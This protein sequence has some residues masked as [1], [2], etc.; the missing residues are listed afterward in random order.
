[1]LSPRGSWHPL[2]AEIDTHNFFGSFGVAVALTLELT[3]DNLLVVLLW[4]TAVSRLILLR[5]LTLM[6]AFIVSRHGFF[7]FNGY[8]GSL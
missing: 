7:F 3:V 4:S 5:L 8:G 6:L 2:V 1:M